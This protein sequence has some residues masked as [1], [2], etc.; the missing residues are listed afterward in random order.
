MTLVIYALEF[1][2]GS[3]RLGWVKVL[4]EGTK[5]LSYGSLEAQL[6]S[7]SGLRQPD[8]PVAQDALS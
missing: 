5:L 2:C 1:A 6:R 8:Y 3:W 7:T 4:I